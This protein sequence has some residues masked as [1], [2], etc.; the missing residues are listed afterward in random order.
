MVSDPCGFSWLAKWLSWLI[1]TFAEII[2]LFD[3][4]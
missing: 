4:F 2:R 3:Y 1:T